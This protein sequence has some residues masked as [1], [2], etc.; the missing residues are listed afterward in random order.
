MSIVPLIISP[1]L[2]LMASQYPKYAEIMQN[3]T[4]MRVTCYTWTG[5]KTASG[6]YPEEGM[7]AG[8]YEDMG[9]TAF[10]YDLNYNFIGAFEI[11]DCGGA[12]SLQNGTSIDIY[13]DTLERC[14]EWVGE[15]GDYLYVE[16]K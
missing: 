14:Y 1:I 3:T 5:N 6:V 12:Y 9:K 11:T 2:L 7:C 16:I 8:R 15:Y 4:Y 10:V 13:R